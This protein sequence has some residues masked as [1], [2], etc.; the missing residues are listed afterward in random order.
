M[1]AVAERLAGAE[2]FTPALLPFECA[3]II[4]RLELGGLISADQ[5]AQAHA[6]LLELPVELWPYEALAGRAWQLRSNATIYD[7]AYVAL[8]EAIGAPLVTADRRLQR[9][10]GVSCAV[11]APPAR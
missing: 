8:A 1:V 4:R 3:N 5:A 10:P 2:L 7:A 11:E 6:D 9:A